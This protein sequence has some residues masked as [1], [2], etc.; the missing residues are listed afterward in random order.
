MKLAPSREKKI[1]SCI[2]EERQRR[3][4]FYTLYQGMK[5]TTEKMPFTSCFRI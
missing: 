4:M 5:N 1:I 3:S 2:S